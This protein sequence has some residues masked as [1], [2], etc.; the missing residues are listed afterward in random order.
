[1]SIISVLS[2][3]V[4]GAVIGYCTNYIAVKMLFHPRNP[5]SV[6][7]HTL[8]FTPGIIPKR[9]KDLAKAV[10]KA[11][12][13]ELFGGQEVKD[14]LLADETRRVVAEGLYSQ[15]EKF[16]NSDRTV[17]ELLCEMSGPEAYEEKKEILGSILTDK[18]T[19]GI[20]SMDIGQVI[21]DK[22]TSFIGEKMNNPLLA[23]FMTPDTI[24]AIASPIGDQVVSYVETEGREKIAEYVYAEISALEQKQ[25][26]ELLGGMEGSRPALMEKL[27]EMYSGFVEEHADA[28]VKQFRIREIIEDRIAGMSNKALEDLVLSV[29]KNELGM[30]VNLGAVIGAV[31]GIV[32]IFI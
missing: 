27:Q 29:M 5:V 15:M 23:M 21:T 1:M 8:P 10:G 9:K 14:I 20:V 16:I 17:Q 26:A 7:G 18:I 3:P 28:V 25:P 22:G 12:E 24:Q 6:G 30:I 32:N 19:E 4:I 2:G 31:I 11:V 13:D